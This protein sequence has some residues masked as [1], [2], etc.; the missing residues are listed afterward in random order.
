ML[1]PILFFFGCLNEKNVNKKYIPSQSPSYYVLCSVIMY[2]ST[3]PRT[4]PI[5]KHNKTH[6]TCMNT[7]SFDGWKRVY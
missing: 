6:N 1:N 5:I 3:P 7:E 2:A 4:L